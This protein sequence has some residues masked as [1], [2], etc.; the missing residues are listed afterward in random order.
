MEPSRY[1]LIVALSHWITLWCRNPR[2]RSEGPK[3]G[4]DNSRTRIEVDPGGEGVFAKI[5]A[6][7]PFVRIRRKSG[8]SQDHF[9]SENKELAHMYGPWPFTV[10]P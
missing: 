6:R 8:G 1:S 2:E 3:N 7:R 5:L 9:V 4:G 10:G